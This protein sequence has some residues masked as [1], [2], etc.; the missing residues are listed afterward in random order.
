M[1]KA[2]T[3]FRL[4]LVALLALVATGCTTHVFN[5]FVDERIPQNASNIYTFSFA[6]Q[7]P[8]GN[9]VEDSLRAYLV[10]N[11]ETYQMERAPQN[12]R[13][14][15]YD[16]R[17][18]PGQVEVRYYYYIEYEYVNQGARGSTVRYSTEEYYGRPYAARLINRYP[19]QLISSRG[20]V[21]DEIAV[22]GSGFSELDTIYVGGVAAETTFNS[23]HSIDFQVPSLDPG[24]AYDVVL[25]TASGELSMGTFRVDGSALRVSPG[26]VRLA[27]GDVTQL[28]F[29]IDSVAPSGGLPITVSSNIPQSILL[30]EV[31]IPAGY[32]S[33]VV[34]IEAGSP[35]SGQIYVEA[36]GFAMQTV[37]VTVE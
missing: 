22:V 2:Q 35:G 3:R 28:T 12:P 5:N 37:N 7:L 10:I 18:P 13:I 11:E 31:S 15:T 14:F 8:A 33:T 4:L 29:Q 25:Q 9:I 32:S 20:R 6:A 26:R 19:I 21:G 36:P 17:L 24:Q 30:P 27:A 16:Y 23:P 1:K 34:T